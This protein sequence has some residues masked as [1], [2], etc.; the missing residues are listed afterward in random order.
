M[1][2]LFD[3]S[4]QWITGCCWSICGTECGRLQFN[5]GCIKLISLPPSRLIAEDGAGPAIQNRRL[6]NPGKTNY[7]N[8][9]R[10]SPQISAVF[11]LWLSRWPETL[12]PARLFTSHGFSGRNSYENAFFHR[13]LAK[14]PLFLL[15][16]VGL[17]L[18]LEVGTLLPWEWLL[19]FALLWPN[20]YF[21]RIRIVMVDK[22]TS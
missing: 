20:P 11:T 19:Q 16:D 3:L 18:L 10:R 4:K 12:R 6:I 22:A 14:T 17:G 8:G 7:P 15:S 9:Q 1:L 2:V 5:A 13:H 21:W